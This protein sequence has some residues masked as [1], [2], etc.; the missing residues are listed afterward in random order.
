MPARTSSRRTRSPPPAS[1]RRDYGLVDGRPRDEPR[2]GAARPRRPPTPPRPPTRPAAL[3]DGR[4]RARR[5]GPP[6]SRRTSSDPG[7]RNVTFDELAEA[8]QEAAEGLIE[9]GADLLVIETIFDTL[10]AKAAIFGVEAAYDA[11]GDRHPADHL[12]HDH[13]RLGPDAVGPDRRGVL[14][15][16]RARPAD[17]RRAQLRPRRAAAARPH[18]RPGADRRA[19]GQRLPERRPA[20]R[21][22]RLRR[23]ARDHGPSS[24]AS[25]R[26]TASIN[27][28]GGCCGTT[29]AHVRAI[30][31]AV[32]G[33]PPRR[34]PGRSR[35][36]RGCPAS[37]RST[38]P[39]PGGV[40]VNV[41]ERTN[42]TGSR[43]FAKLILEDRFDEAV[44]V[45][46]QQ[47]DAGAQLIDVNMDEAMLDSVAAMTRFLNLIASEPDIS[48]VP[49]MIDSSRWEVIEAGLKCVQGKR[50][51]QLD[52][53]QGGRGAVPRAR[54]AVPPLRR[55]GRRHGVRRAGPGRHRRPQGRD[56]ARGRTS[57]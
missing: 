9:G 8:Y 47:V 20:Q 21:V 17:R 32:A 52:L 6:R 46:R 28:A 49:V 10:N 19:A 40:F 11:A 35:A 31:E 24:S 7:A 41:G 54:P 16:G 26:A 50:R 15:L 25:S 48:T 12:G 33:V 29:P 51:R 45:A 14:D 1:P 2:G 13:R 38:I 44:E 57:S 39:Q 18:R 4:A 37:R 34:R 42:V 36:R 30:A 56:R 23:D 43:K 5:T 3:R 22:R 55:R 53:A 27:I